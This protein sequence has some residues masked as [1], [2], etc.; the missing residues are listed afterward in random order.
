MLD[1]PEI[2]NSAHEYE[3]SKV[4]APV[5]R[6]VGRRFFSGVKDGKDGELSFQHG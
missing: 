6:G 5:G 2:L 4:K 3:T 1:E